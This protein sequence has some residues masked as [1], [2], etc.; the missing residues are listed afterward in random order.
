MVVSA[1]RA[2]SVT[3]HMVRAGVMAIDSNV[4]QGEDPASKTRHRLVGNLAFDAIK[5]KT[6][7]ITPV[8]GE[9]DRR[10]LLCRWSTP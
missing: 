2:E 10:P 7:A 1:N 5:E 8:P 9:V 4:N 3:A 6:Q